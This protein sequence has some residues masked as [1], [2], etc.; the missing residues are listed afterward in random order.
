MRIGTKEGQCKVSRWPCPERLRETAYT[1]DCHTGLS[2]TGKWSTGE[3]IEQQESRAALK[4]FADD[5]LVIQ[6]NVVLSCSTLLPESPT[7]T[8]RTGTEIWNEFV[9]TSLSCCAVT[10]SMSRNERS[11]P[12]VSPSTERRTCS[13]S[14]SP[15][16]PTTTSRSLS[17]GSPG[18]WSGECS[19]VCPRRCMR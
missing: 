18:S 7:R 12:P 3:M 5:Y 1:R 16:S 8:Y 6:V 14:K 11:R 10:R 17:F 15:P 9:K 13:T 19:R 2:R 4:T